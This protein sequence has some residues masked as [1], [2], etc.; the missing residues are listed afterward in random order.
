M[1]GNAQATHVQSGMTN[2][3]VEPTQ[4]AQHQNQENRQDMNQSV[5]GAT[6]A[7]GA[8]GR[9]EVFILPSEDFGMEQFNRKVTEWAV[10]I[11]SY[12]GQPR[13]PHFLRRGAHRLS[14]RELRPRA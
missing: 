4:R 10:V 6:V 8:A 3:V 11:R 2:D 9:F 13:V 12:S 1:M 7:G 14:A 5:V